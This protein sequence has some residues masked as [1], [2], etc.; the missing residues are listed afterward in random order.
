[1]YDDFPKSAMLQIQRM[2]KNILEDALL[3]KALHVVPV[4]NL[5]AI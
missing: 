4:F 1:M 3:V 5:H 2:R